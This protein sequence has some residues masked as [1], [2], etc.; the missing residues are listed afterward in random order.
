MVIVILFKWLIMLSISSR[1]F[2]LLLIISSKKMFLN[3]WFGCMYIF[4]FC[5]G[6]TYSWKYCRKW[7]VHCA[8]ICL[9]IKLWNKHESVFVVNFNSRHLNISFE[10]ISDNLFL[11]YI[12]SIIYNQWFLGSINWWIGTQHIKNYLEAGFESLLY[13]ITILPAI[14]P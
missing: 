2:L 6:H 7:S 1:Y 14:R 3:L 8:S 10:Y 4:S 9:F 13:K 11:T 12:S 5:F